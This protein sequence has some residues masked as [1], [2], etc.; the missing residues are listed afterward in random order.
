MQNL[1]FGMVFPQKYSSATDCHVHHMLHENGP[2]SCV[3][4]FKEKS[5]WK[6]ETM[7]DNNINFHEL[8]LARG[9]DIL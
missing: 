7:W 8:I 4:A 6:S 1:N 2:I 3:R 9:R 5:V